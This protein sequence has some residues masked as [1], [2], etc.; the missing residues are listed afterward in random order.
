MKTVYVVLGSVCLGLGVL[1]IIIPLLPTTPFLLLTAYFY[2]RGSDKF[3]H[4]FLNTK[5][6][7]KYLSDFVQNRSMTLCRK[8]TLMI[9][10]DVMLLIPFIL[11][12]S[13]WVRGLIVFLASYKYFY[14]FTKIKTI[15]SD[16]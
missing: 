9:M 12:D 5:L 10:V 16:L 8:W 7:K 3:H 1:G 14:F 11:T 6:F 4:W 2:A 13:W 15:P